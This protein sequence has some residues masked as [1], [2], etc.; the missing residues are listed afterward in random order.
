MEKKNAPPEES[1]SESGDSEPKKRPLPASLRS[2]WEKQKAKA[3]VKRKLKEEPVAPKSFK[4]R[5][6][7][8]EER[9]ARRNAKKAE[10]AKAAE[11]EEDDNE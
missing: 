10:F 1:G 3:E 7:N 9:L 2:L 6:F 5:R 4:Q 8:T 11:A